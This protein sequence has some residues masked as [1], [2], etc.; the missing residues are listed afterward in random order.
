MCNGGGGW[1]VGDLV[2]CGVWVGF[3]RQTFLVTK[4]TAA[5]E[6]IG[7]RIHSDWLG[8]AVWLE[9]RGLGSV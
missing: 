6:H 1:S 7:L 5:Q 9:P 3:P 4:A 2:G 8:L